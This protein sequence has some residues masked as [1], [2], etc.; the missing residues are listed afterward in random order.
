[1]YVAILQ[2]RIDELGSRSYLGE[3][4]PS[5][6]TPTSYAATVCG[7]LALVFCNDDTFSRSGSLQGGLERRVVLGT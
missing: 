3:S 1:M 5:G 7:R 4:L 2:H 6:T